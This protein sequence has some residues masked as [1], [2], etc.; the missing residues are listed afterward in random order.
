MCFRQRVLPP[1]S[2]CQRVLTGAG[3]R[4]NCFLA[5]QKSL[6]PSLCVRTLRGGCRPPAGELVTVDIAESQT[7]SVWPLSWVLRLH[8][9]E[10]VQ[11][12]AGI[13]QCSL[14]GCC[15]SH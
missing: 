1:L 13:P 8:P 12:H 2:K 6:P 7:L 10:E 5:P 9:S 15:T 11:G 4:L 3:E 14:C